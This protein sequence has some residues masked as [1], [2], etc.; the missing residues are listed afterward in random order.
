MWF[1]KISIS[2]PRWDIANSKGVGRSQNPKIMNVISRVMLWL[3]KG[4]LNHVRVWIL[5]EAMKLPGRPLNIVQNCP[6]IFSNNWNL[7]IITKDFWTSSLVPQNMVNNLHV[8]TCVNIVKNLHILHIF[9]LSCVEAQVF[10]LLS[11][12]HCNWTSMLIIVWE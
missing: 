11:L 12:V 2:T 4:D 3:G 8:R 10:Y 6:K 5:S 1:H 7:L 9:T